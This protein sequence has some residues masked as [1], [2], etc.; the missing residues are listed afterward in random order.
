[1]QYYGWELGVALTDASSQKGNL[2]PERAESKRQKKKNKKGRKNP[3][4]HG[5]STLNSFILS[6]SA[7]KKQTSITKSLMLVN[8]S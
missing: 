2:L 7:I 8:F 5:L 3:S 1:M 6:S 4:L